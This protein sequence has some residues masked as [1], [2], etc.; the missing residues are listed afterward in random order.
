MRETQGSGQARLIQEMIDKQ[1]SSARGL[2]VS[3]S[4]DVYF[5]PELFLKLHVLLPQA[6]VLLFDL[7][8]MLYLLAG[9]LVPDK[10]SILFLQLLK[11]ELYLRLLVSEEFEGKSQLLHFLL[12]LGVL[13]NQ[14]LVFLGQCLQAL[15][16]LLV[17][18]QDV[19]QLLIFECDQIS[20]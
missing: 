5:P 1:V 13:G 15:L 12:L 10:E 7:E 16:V 8:M 17:L 4:H 11:L 2:H 20:E 6:V 18:V 3:R 9:V 14:L 19:F